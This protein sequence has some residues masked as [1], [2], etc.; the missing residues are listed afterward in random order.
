M[1]RKIRKGASR[2]VFGQHSPKSQA[3]NNT[4]KSTHTQDK[5]NGRALHS[6]SGY[7]NIF[8]TSRKTGR[9]L[10]GLHCYT[11]RLIAAPLRGV[12]LL[13][14]NRTHGVDMPIILTGAPYGNPK[15]LLF[16]CGQSANLY[17]VAHPLGGGV[18]FTTDNLTQGKNAMSKPLNGA[19]A[20]TQNTAF[21]SPYFEQSLPLGMCLKAVTEPVSRDALH[22][23]K[24]EINTILAQVADTLDVI[25]ERENV[26][27]KCPSYVSYSDGGQAGSATDLMAALLRLTIDMNTAINRKLEGQQ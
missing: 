5:T 14:V 12:F 19:I 17:G 15:G 21:V 18:G 22:T 9:R 1:R 27:H 24:F 25:A 26:A 3:E 4:A 16:P 8:L 2:A 11:R 7:V 20:H 10:G 6:A 23:A 13:V